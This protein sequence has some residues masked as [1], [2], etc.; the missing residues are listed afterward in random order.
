MR[1]TTLLA[2]TLVLLGANFVNAQHGR[3]GGSRASSVSAPPLKGII[4]TTHG[5]LKQI[6]K[7]A[8]LI[9]SDDN[10]IIT[11]R[12][13]GKTKFLRDGHDAKPSDFDL[14]SAV[15][16]DA[17]ED[18]DLKFLA[19]AVRPDPTPKKDLPSSSR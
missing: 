19:I 9:Q 10:Q 3:R 16:V 5:V 1:H 13:T 2:A 14:E 4:I 6:T 17:V 11:F 15:T 8:I 12:R 18:N 7:K